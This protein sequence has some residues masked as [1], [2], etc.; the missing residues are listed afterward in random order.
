MKRPSG[1]ICAPEISGLPKKSSRSMSGGSLPFCAEIVAG[2][3]NTM[4]TASDRRTAVRRLT[5]VLIWLSRLLV[6]GGNTKL[7]LT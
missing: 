7:A 3:V 4:A 1:E 5:E 2:A 6:G